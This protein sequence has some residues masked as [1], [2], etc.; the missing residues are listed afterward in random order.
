MSLLSIVLTN[1]LRQVVGALSEAHALG[2]VHRDLKPDNIM[3]TI[4]P[5]GSE[6]Y[7][8]L[9]FGIAKVVNY[10]GDKGDSALTQTGIVIGTPQ[11]MSPEQALVKP[12]D[13][14]ADIYA[15]GIILYELLCGAVP[16]RAGSLMEMLMQH[17]NDKPMALRKFKPE[18]NIPKDVEK[19]VLKSLE[20]DPDK[21]QQSVN[22][23]LDDFLDALPPVGAG[24]KAPSR[25]GLVAGGSLLLLGIP[26]AGYLLRGS[27]GV[28][29]AANKTEK[30]EDFGSLSITSDPQGA[31]VL[32]NNEAKGETPLLIKGV[33]RGSYEV[34]VRLNG[35][36][37]RS[38]SL[39]VAP[40]LTYAMT[41]P[42]EPV[43][44][45]DEKPE[46]TPKPEALPE[47]T[48]A[49]KQ[50]T[51]EPAESPA[52]DA[53]RDKL[54]EELSRFA[55]LESDRKAIETNAKSAIDQNTQS[56]PIL[57][58]APDKVENAGKQE[59]PVEP[60]IPAKPDTSVKP[61][62]EST[63]L[64]PSKTEEPVKAEKS[65]SEAEKTVTP[66]AK[67]PEKTSVEVQKTPVKIKPAEVK[68]TPEAPKARKT[69]Q[70]VVVQKTA[71]KKPIPKNFNVA[72][73][74][75]SAGQDDLT[76][77]RSSLASAKKLY[78]QGKY[79]QAVTQLESIVSKEK[80][81]VAALNLLGNAYL[82]MGKPA[83][84]AVKRFRDALMVQRN[85]PE[86][87]YNLAKAYAKLGNVRLMFRELRSA[88]QLN[89][90]YK[91]R[92]AKDPAFRLH[93]DKPQFKSL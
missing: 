6:W 35:Y 7:E 48:E 12:L 20:K 8:V 36:A 92:A 76:A 27:S 26:L 71:E 32:V 59:L 70:V 78:S 90:A 41:F 9:D 72:S 33:M 68:S 23:L 17:I 60:G 21:R 55:K 66:P 73:L 11:Y 31:T 2:I 64:A 56:E 57:T 80:R 85:N 18:R 89:K 3:M 91:S 47:A 65:S 88:V 4:R 40:G 82:K 75:K 43:E 19:V 34:I 5:N 63:P 84:Y 38:Y 10:E 15:L 62:A 61:E 42:L 81:N 58:P 86:S 28:Q 77:G 54:R 16:F 50:V 30:A 29:P 93:R 44:E 45:L 46:V 25:L 79:S 37:E 22:Q 52:P 74:S 83:T 24:S 69:P 39:D 67:E 49:P 14:R 53:E 13:S 1:F 87:H 51:A